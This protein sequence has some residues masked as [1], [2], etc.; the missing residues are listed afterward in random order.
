MP[1]WDDLGKAL[2]EEMAGYPYSVALDA[3]SAYS[4]EYSRIKLVER[5][6]ELLL[7]DQAVPG[8]AHRA[9]CSIPFELV[10]T[11][12]FDFLLERQYSAGPRYCR[13]VIDEEQLSISVGGSRV[14]LLKLHGDLHH[15]QRLVL[16]EDDYDRFLDTYPLM[17]T[18]AASMLIYKTPLLLG[19]SL[20]DPDFRKLWQIIGDRLGKLRRPAY[21]IMIDAHATEVARF[22]RRGV[23]VISI[24]GEKAK[25]GEI[26]A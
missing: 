11:T 20:D 3:I 8:E 23:R 9:F 10:F 26:L 14:L 6:F 16:T 13:P 21:S 5:L 4:H 1:A 7:V 19:Y 2:S 17:A 12:N 24:E 18:F 15:P 22:A 25:Y